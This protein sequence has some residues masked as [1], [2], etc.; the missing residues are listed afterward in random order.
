[1]AVPFRRRAVSSV[2]RA[3]SSDPLERIDSIG[4]F[5]SDRTRWVLSQTAAIAKIE[6][7]QDEFYVRSGEENV[8]LVV[9][10][11]SGEKYLQSEREHTHPDEL[12]QLPVV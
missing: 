6:A 1:M 10:T 2:S 12:L 5:N 8:K 3:Y 7:G 9:L 4:G 11:K